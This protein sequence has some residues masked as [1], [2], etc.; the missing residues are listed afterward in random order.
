MITLQSQKFSTSCFQQSREPPNKVY[1][2]ASP[3]WRKSLSCALGGLLLVASVEVQKQ[4][5][6]VGRTSGADG[7]MACDFGHATLLDVKANFTKRGTP[8]QF[9]NSH[10]SFSPVSRMLLGVGSFWSP[11]STS[12]MSAAKYSGRGAQAASANSARSPAANA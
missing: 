12:R 7:H 6:R 2:R 5:D 10:G 11:S 4:R 1:N 9:Q 3:M 8:I